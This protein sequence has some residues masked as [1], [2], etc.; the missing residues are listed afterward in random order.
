MAVRSIRRQ[1]VNPG[2]YSGTADAAPIFVDSD[3]N[4]LGIIP[5][6]SG[7][8][9]VDVVD[10]SSTQTLT[11]KTLTSPTISGPVFSGTSEIADDARLTLGDDNDQVLVNRSATNA[12]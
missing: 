9:V 8:T 7:T 5:A 1:A 12:A 10:V 6:G 4:I 11:N 2:A 3:T